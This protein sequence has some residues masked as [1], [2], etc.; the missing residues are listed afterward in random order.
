M[1]NI[2]KR[3]VAVSMIMIMAATTL[4][5]CNSNKKADGKSKE[6]KQEITNQAFVDGKK[7]FDDYMNSKYNKKTKKEAE[8]IYSYTIRDKEK[9]I[10]VKYAFVYLK[11]DE[12]ADKYIDN[13]SGAF[14][15]DY[16]SEYD[17]GEKGVAIIP[18][19]DIDYPSYIL[20]KK[21]TGVYTV[22]YEDEYEADAKEFIVE[23]TK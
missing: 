14:S 16:V 13:V 23:V 2:F 6:T 17:A 22:S 21:G 11:S 5:G 1:R 3:T 15:D 10:L 18:S 9:N 12:E 4:S 7:V 19:D 20:T 8:N